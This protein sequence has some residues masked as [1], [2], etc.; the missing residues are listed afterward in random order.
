MNVQLRHPLAVHDLGDDVGAL[1]LR[2]FEALGP[3]Q[4]WQKPWTLGYP[5]ASNG[6]SPFFCQRTL[7]ARVLELARLNDFVIKQLAID[8]PLVV[9]G[10][11]ATAMTSVTAA[12]M[13]SIC[14][15]S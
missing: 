13:S 8:D 9:S 1:D 15:R 11:V 10:C 3:V 4:D 7:T 5:V 6:L 2:L 14:P 12:A